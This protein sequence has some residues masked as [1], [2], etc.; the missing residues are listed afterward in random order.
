MK[1][2]IFNMFEKSG[3]FCGQVEIDAY[4]MQDAAMNALALF[5]NAFTA[6][7]P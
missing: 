4:N 6:V 3:E 2:Y 1:R 7:Y 5:R